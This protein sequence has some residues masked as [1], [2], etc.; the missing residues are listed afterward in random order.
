MSSVSVLESR[1]Y[2]LADYECHRVLA[3]EG[4]GG[5]NSLELQALQVVDCA[6]RHA[7]PLYD[8]CVDEYYS[9]RRYNF[10]G[11]YGTELAQLIKEDVGVP[12]A[13]TG[14]KTP[15]LQ[16]HINRLGETEDHTSLVYYVGDGTAIILDGVIRLLKAGFKPS[17]SALHVNWTLAASLPYE[18]IGMGL[19]PLRDEATGRVIITQDQLCPG[20][21]PLPYDELERIMHTDQV[22]DDTITLSDGQVIDARRF[23]GPRMR[24]VHA[25]VRARMDLLGR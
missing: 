6:D 10:C 25:G 11:P 3:S 4:R 21:L 20:T 18:F 15:H 8:S 17:Y 1:L 5:Y 24:A 9:D 2:T 16:L 22:Y 13:Q 12:L 19:A 23:W 14:P 7:S